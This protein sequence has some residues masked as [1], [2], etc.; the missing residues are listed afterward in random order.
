VPGY[1]ALWQG[2]GGYTGSGLAV[3]GV[4]AGTYQATVTDQN[5]CSRTVTTS[6]DQPDALVLNIPAVADTI[7]FQ[8]SN[9]SVSVVASGGNGGYSFSWS[10]G[11]SG[12]TSAGL[13]AGTYKVTVT[14]L[15]G[16]LISGQ[17]VVP[18]KEQ[19]SAAALTAN[20][21]CHDGEDGY[22][23]VNN[24]RYGTTAAS[25][26]AFQYL[27]NTTPAQTAQTAINLGA[28]KSYSVTVTDQ[29][30]CSAT[31]GF[32][33]D[34]PVAMVAAVTGKSDVL[35]NGDP[36]GWASAKA[37]GG[38]APYTWKW[39]NSSTPADSVGRGLLA[40]TNK[41]TISDVFGCDATV[42][43]EI[44]EPARLIGQAIPTHVKCYGERSGEATITAF[45]GVTPYKYIWWNGVTDKQVTGLPAGEI[46]VTVTDA[47]GCATP[48]I[49]EILQPEIPI[50]GQV[51]LSE[52]TCRGYHDGRIQILPAGGSPPYRYALN[53][54]PWNGSSVQIGLYAGQYIPQIADAN[55]CTVELPAAQLNEPSGVSADL[56]PDLTIEF[57]QD[58]QLFLEVSN[59]VGNYSVQWAPE[60]TSW[61]DCTNCINPLVSGLTNP[62]Y[63]D[64]E[65]TDQKGCRATD[66]VLI[67]VIVPRKVHVPTAFSPNGDYV[68]DLLLVHGQSESRA[69]TFRVYDRWG[70]L[71]YEASDFAFNDDN[72]GWDGNFRGQPMDP[73]VFVWV[74]EAKFADGHTEVFRGNTTLVR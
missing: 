5:G 72:T 55:G 7:C 74:L 27:W 12:P 51:V 1:T 47:N 70:E 53:D 35:C 21:R 34:N 58:V 50:T 14:D 65:V 29:D 38:T 10:N 45:G 68:N 6:V 61:L 63:F 54:K 8:G 3:T 48:V 26:A 41:V 56:G 42:T 28:D 52:P 46:G 49:T 23:T 16:C 13:A 59:A 62:H 30:G 24:I 44:K 9:G 69:L 32:T 36:T 31:L 15:K 18:Q 17:S 4:S 37:I 60:D 25:P 22:A 39:A 33:L 66:Q 57:G 20:P 43:V 67:Q 2:P 19:L 73:G 11:Q 40:G 71:V 64:A